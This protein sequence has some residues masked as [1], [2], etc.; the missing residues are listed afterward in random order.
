V[1]LPAAMG[2]AVDLMERKDQTKAG[3]II[4]KNGE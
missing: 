3:F 2:I 1:I 4:M